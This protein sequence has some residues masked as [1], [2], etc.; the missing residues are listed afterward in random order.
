MG[1]ERATEL[2]LL[3]VFFNDLVFN[4]ITLCRFE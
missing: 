4:V 2:T 3:G 1:T